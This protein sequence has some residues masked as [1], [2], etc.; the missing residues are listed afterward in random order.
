MRRLVE[1]FKLLHDIQLKKIVLLFSCIALFA[2]NDKIKKL[3]Y[4]GNHS[5]I[6]SKNGEKV[7][8]FFSVPDFRLVNQDSVVITNQSF[9]GKVYIAD[10]IFLKCPTICPIMNVELKRVYDVY[11]DNMN[12]LFASHT[13]D[14][15]NDSIPALKAYSDQL[16]VEATKWFFLHGEKNDIYHLAEKGYFSQAYENKEVPGG[17]AHSGGFLLVDAQRHI[18]GVYD[19]TNTEDVDRLISEIEILLKEK[20]D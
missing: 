2:C 20:L 5:E 7:Q 9:N 4:L 13:I 10:F 17:Y 16:G 19:G 3:P 14:P 6:V 18:R 11:K 15:E 12:V 1:R 8:S